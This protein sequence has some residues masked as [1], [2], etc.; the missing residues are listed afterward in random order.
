[1]RSAGNTCIV[2][3][4]MT[5]QAPKAT[6]QDEAAN[7]LIAK[8]R[9][10]AKGIAAIGDDFIEEQAKTVAAETA[11]EKALADLHAAKVEEEDAT[12]TL[13]T[14]RQVIEDYRRGIL[15]RDELFGRTVGHG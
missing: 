8:L 1:M 3:D 5:D 13:A 2:W 15:D 7:D 14:W 11:M 12:L 10:V 4:G 9:V 6:S